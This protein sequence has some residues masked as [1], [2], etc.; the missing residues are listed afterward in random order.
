MKVAE[1]QNRFV[2]ELKRL[3]PEWQFVKSHRAFK[4]RYEDVTWRLHISCINHESDFD[5]VGDVAVEY[6]TGS[7][8]VCVFGAELGNIEGSGQ[9]RFRVSSTSEALKSAHQLYSFFDEI[10]LPY[11]AKYSKPTEVVSAL[12]KGGKDAMRVSPLI[13]QHE[14][15][16]RKLCEK[17]GINL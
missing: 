7:E 16:I 17:Y 1:L 2:A 6:K 8:S 12:R 5:A 14:T 15:H 10:G 11:L 13:S 9:A 3:L 4:R